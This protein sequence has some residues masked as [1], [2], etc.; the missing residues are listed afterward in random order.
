[1]SLKKV[2]KKI[3]FKN[4]RKS[5]F[6]FISGDSFRHIS[7]HIYDE[8]KTINPEKIKEGDI[9]FIRSDMLIDFFEK[10]A[11]NIDNHYILISHN[12][13]ENIDEKYFK[14]IDEK[15][16]HWFAQNNISKHPK[17]TPIPIG[18]ENICY[19]GAGK[20]K[21]YNKENNIEPKTN[22]IITN[23][24]LKTNPTQ[25]QAALDILKRITL[26]DIDLEI[27]PQKK[28][29]DRLRN[30]RFVASPEGNGVDCHRTWECLYLKSIPIVT[31][32]YFI[33]YFENLD[34]PILKIQD[35]SD[36]EKYSEEQLDKFYKENKDKFDTKHLHMEYW[37]D[38]IK[39]YKNSC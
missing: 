15:I 35:W 25:R 23:F 4:K 30:Y 31:E 34:I 32:R 26:A 37:V 5:S 10:I 14:Y 16:I 39:N 7:D 17:I 22:R 20:L 11:V 2:T 33:N 38:K 1:M 21:F 36:L 13:D 12:S 29:I 19:G 9:I 24:N 27:L 18:L 3:L 6:P 8:S 28:H